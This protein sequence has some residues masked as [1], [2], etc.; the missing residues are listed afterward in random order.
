MVRHTSDLESKSK[1]YRSLYENF[2]QRYMDTVQQQ[3]FPIA[4]AHVIT[5]AMPPFQTSYPKTTF[6][7]LLGLLVGMPGPAAFTSVVAQSYRARPYDVR[8]SSVLSA[9]AG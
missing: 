6:V 4:D 8:S 7:A 3:S 9:L 2:L 5:L 1:T